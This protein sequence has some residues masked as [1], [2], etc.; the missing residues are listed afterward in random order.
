[1][2]SSEADF[3]S[4]FNCVHIPTE[5]FRLVET[6]VHLS[7]VYRHYVTNA[8]R[9]LSASLTYKSPTFSEQRVCY[10]GPCLL[11]GGGGIFPAPSLDMF[12]KVLLITAL[13]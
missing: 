5:G 11:R 8:T 7:A 6:S 4:H 3:E 1:M 13:H 12:S 9:F 2:A 10:C